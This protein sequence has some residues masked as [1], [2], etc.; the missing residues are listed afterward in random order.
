MSAPAVLHERSLWYESNPSVL[1]T[2]R[3][4]R[5]AKNAAGQP[6]PVKVIYLPHRKSQAPGSPHETTAEEV[7][8]VRDNSGKPGLYTEVRWFPAGTSDWKDLYGAPIV[9]PIVFRKAVSK[10]LLDLYAIGDPVMFDWEKLPSNWMIAFLLGTPGPMVGVSGT[11][12]WRGSEGLNNGKGTNPGRQSAWTDASFQ[13]GNYSGELLALLDKFGFAF[14]C[15]L[16]F[17]LMQPV[18]EREDAIR[19]LRDYGFPGIDVLPFYDAANQPG[20]NNWRKGCVFTSNR[21]NY[22]LT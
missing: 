9:D 2:A 22:L 10:E 4:C 1:T 11:Q 18:V 20:P 6:N 3:K 21:W 7:K 12:G 5:D 17:A 13:V 14:F 15:Q 8:Q 19:G 16:Y